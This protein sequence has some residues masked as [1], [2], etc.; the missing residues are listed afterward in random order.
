MAAVWIVDRISGLFCFAVNLF[1]DRVSC[2]FCFAVCCCLVDLP[3]VSSFVWS[4]A[5]LGI[6]SLM[7]RTL[8]TLAVLCSRNPPY[9][10]VS[11][12]ISPDMGWWWWWW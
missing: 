4:Q 10:E 3:L 11:D 9:I 7:E 6:T 5:E 1:V 12:A 8:L 2:A